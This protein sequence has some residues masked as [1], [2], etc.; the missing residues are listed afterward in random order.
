MERNVAV[1]KPHTG[2]VEWECDGEIAASI[3]SLRI[4]ADGSIEIVR[5]TL[6]AASTVADD[7]D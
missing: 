7:E 6:S 3:D 2:I 4:T 5:N 1:H